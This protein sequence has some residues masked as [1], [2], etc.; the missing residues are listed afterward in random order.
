MTVLEEGG[1]FRWFSYISIS[2]NYSM[3]IVQ[4]LSIVHRKT[5]VQILYDQQ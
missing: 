2:R 3:L 5:N 1:I 4:F